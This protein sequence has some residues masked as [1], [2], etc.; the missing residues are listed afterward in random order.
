MRGR[1]PPSS[2]STAARSRGLLSI[3]AASGRLSVENHGTIKGGIVSTRGGHDK[4][5]NDGTIKGYVYLGPGDDLYKNA[6]GKAGLVFGGDGNDTLIA[7]PHADKFVFDTPPNAATNVDTVKHF[8]PGT[9][10][11]FLVHGIFTMLTGPGTLK[12]KE[13]HVGK[14]AGDAN[15]YII[16]NKHTGALYYDSD[17]SGVDSAQVQFAQVREGPPP[18]PRRFHGVRLTLSRPWTPCCSDA[19]GPQFCR[20]GSALSGPRNTPL[21]IAWGRV[22][23]NER[24]D[25]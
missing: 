19:A 4:V 17:G 16:Y 6:G 15:D 2:T 5:V 24:D 12:G 21:V 14:H 23:H 3:Y 20:V 1:P 7:G 25:D 18:P 11:F 9:D 13:F 10:E 8:D 22:Y